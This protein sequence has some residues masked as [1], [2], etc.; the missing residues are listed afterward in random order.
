VLLLGELTHRLID[1]GNA[2]HANED[3]VR[4]LPFFARESTTLQYADEYVQVNWYPLGTYIVEQGDVGTSIYLILSREVD[5]VREE[6]DGTL[7]TS[8]HK[9]AGQFFGELDLVFYQVR[10]AHILAVRA[11]PAYIARRSGR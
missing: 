8:D 10:M 5:V 11:T 6:P 2:F 1:L 3:F 7:H 4:A 9:G